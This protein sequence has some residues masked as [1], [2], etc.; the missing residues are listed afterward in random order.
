MSSDP[1][2]IGK[3]QDDVHAEVQDEIHV[4][5][6]GYKY[7]MMNGVVMPPYITPSRYELSRTVEM[8]NS[9]LCFTGFPKS[10]ST[11]LSYIL[12]LLVHRGE[13]PTEKT[14]RGS[15]HWV[16]SSFTYPRSRDELASHPDPRIFKSHMPFS[17]A[18][19][20]DPLAGPCK[21]IYIARNPKDVC[22]SYFKFESDKSWA[23]GYSGPFEHWLEMFQNGQVQRGDWFDHVLSWW[24][25]RN[26]DFVHFMTYED[27]RFE[28]DE[29]VSRIAEFLGYPLD[30]NLL[31]IIRSKTDFDSMS[32]ED[33]SSMHEIEELGEFFRKGQVGSWKAEFTETQS[34]AFDALC[35]ARLAGSGLSFRYE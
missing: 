20:G 4:G 17:M 27:L 30:D 5:A 15:L 22:V 2:L 14:L 21:H 32:K 28:F 6:Y 8:R 7:R 34:Q 16:A 18:V 23:G 26:S 11:W 33:F 35:E 3:Y 25:H 24:E 1:P 19:G 13:T 9:D 12:L 29:T 10:G 31:D